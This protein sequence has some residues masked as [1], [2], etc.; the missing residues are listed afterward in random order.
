[1]FILLIFVLSACVQNSEVPFCVA[2]LDSIYEKVVKWQTLLPR[3]RPYYAVKC[4]NTPAVLRTL[5]ALG[6]GFD[7][8]S[9]V[10]ICESPDSS[11]CPYEAHVFCGRGRSRWSWI[12]EWARTESFMPI[13]PNPSHTSDMR[14]REGWTRWLLTLRRSSTRSKRITTAQS[15]IIILI[16]IFLELLTLLSTTCYCLSRLVLRISVDDSK[17]RVKLNTKFGARLEAVGNLLKRAQEL[18]LEIIGVSFH[19]G[20]ECT[21][22]RPY[23]NAIADAQQVFDQAVSLEYKWWRKYIWASCLIVR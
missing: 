21:D 20:C 15:E 23:K 9:K 4:N 18:N 10:S 2:N 12:L 11:L 3:V 16:T 22:T 6:T 7:C 8:A 13:R 1:M 17:S 14:M 5:S 19:V